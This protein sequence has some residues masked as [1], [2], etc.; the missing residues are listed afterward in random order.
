MDYLEK[1]LKPNLFV[2]LFQTVFSLILPRLKDWIITQDKF[3]EKWKILKK[4]LIE[5]LTLNSNE[6]IKF[7][8]EK[9]L[10]ENTTNERL[11]EKEI[12]FTKKNILFLNSDLQIEKIKNKIQNFHS[13]I[14]SSL[15]CGIILLIIHFLTPLI[16]FDL[17]IYLLIISLMLILFQIYSVVLINISDSKFKKIENKILHE[18]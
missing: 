14:F 1:I 17:T 7:F 5:K 15:I 13:Y 11:N 8:I 3:D 10:M 12:E 6:Q 9:P 16:N 4:T 2:L 18:Y